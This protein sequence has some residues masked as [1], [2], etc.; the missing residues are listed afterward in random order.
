[1]YSCNQDGS[2]AGVFPP[3]GTHRV[4]WLRQVALKGI[5]TINKGQ[6]PHWLATASDARRPQFGKVT[7]HDHG[8]ALYGVKNSNFTNREYVAL[9]TR[10]SEDEHLGPPGTHK[11]SN[12]K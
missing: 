7:E 10:R 12:N 11:G 1:M 6:A 9:C 3:H 5:Y 4:P 2:I 8:F